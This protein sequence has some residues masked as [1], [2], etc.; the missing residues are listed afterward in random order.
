V[1]KLDGAG[2]SYIA[3][4]SWKMIIILI[5]RKEGLINMDKMMSWEDLGSGCAFMACAET[6]AELFEKVLEHGRTV[7]GMKEF[8]PDFYDK[9]RASI[10]EGYCDLEDELCQYGE[11]CC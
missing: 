4:E 6:E 2:I 10:R 7:H 9:V 1:K 5:I 3:L 11:C 8:S